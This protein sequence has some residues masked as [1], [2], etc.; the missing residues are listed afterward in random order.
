MKFK[1]HAHGFTLLELLVVVVLLGIITGF[2]VLSIGS[3]GQERKLEE[4][5][6]RLHALMRLVREEA[7]IQ[8]R[9][10]AMQLD[11]KGYHF[12]QYRKK[13][14]QIVKTT[15]FR[16][17]QIEAGLQLQ[18]QTHQPVQFEALEK[19]NRKQQYPR[20]YFFSSGEQTPFVMTLRTTTQRYPYY[21]ISG[22]FD[23]RLQ[24]KKIAS[25]AE[26]TVS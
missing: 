25:F 1:Q 21:R 9:E 14:W 19:K 2:V 6:R 23:G 8:A 7:I 11:D 3:S 17:R 10:M 20:I 5:A 12:L 24:L 18:I 15:V 16:P 4:Q 13:K 22:E 26:D